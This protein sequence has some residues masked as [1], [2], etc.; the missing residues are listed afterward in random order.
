[1]LLR[2]L[3]LFWASEKT[4]EMWV[5][6]AWDASELNREKNILMIPAKILAKSRFLLVRAE[7]NVWHWW[8]MLWWFCDGSPMTIVPQYEG[9]TFNSMETIL[10]LLTTSPPP[11]SA[12]MTNIYTSQKDTHTQILSIP[13]LLLNHH[14]IEITHQHH[15]QNHLKSLHHPDTKA[16]SS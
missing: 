7:F 16:L 15:H 12:A 11:L 1:L 5:R 2:S 8:N 4:R 9:G 14:T 3:C 13:S 6:W 10:L